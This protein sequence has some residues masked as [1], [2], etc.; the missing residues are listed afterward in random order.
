MFLIFVARI[1]KAPCGKPR[2]SR[3]LI[4]A[5]REPSILE[6]SAATRA[7]FRRLQHRRHRRA[8]EPTAE[9]IVQPRALDHII[10]RAVSKMM[11]TLAGARRRHA[12]AAARGPAIHHRVGDVGVKLEAE[13]MARLE[14]LDRK[15]R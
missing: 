8:L 6:R 2:I 1:S 10:L 13:G 15:I 5:T 4:R 14:S 9:E 3:S 7:L 11:V 12:L